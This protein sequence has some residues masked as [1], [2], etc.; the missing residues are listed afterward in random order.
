MTASSAW[1]PGP[2]AL[3][4]RWRSR[5]L[6]RS[7]PAPGDH[8]HPSMQVEAEGVSPGFNHQSLEVH[9]RRIGAPTPGLESNDLCRRVGPPDPRRAL[10]PDRLGIA[11][12]PVP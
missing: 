12:A 9:P 3:A 2:C 5:S 10:V 11:G 1:N 4:V 7:P 6:T 8:G